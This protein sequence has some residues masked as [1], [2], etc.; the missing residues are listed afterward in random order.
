MARQLNINVDN[1]VFATAC[2]CAAPERQRGR[3][4]REGLI[5]SIHGLD[6]TSRVQ[7]MSG[8]VPTDQTLAC[9]LRGQTVLLC[10][11]SEL[12][13]SFPSD[14]RGDDEIVSA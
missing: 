14:G 13:Q 9:L 5:K 8:L 4:S 12:V 6:Q 3:G 1:L 11:S 7:H 2:Y 10:G